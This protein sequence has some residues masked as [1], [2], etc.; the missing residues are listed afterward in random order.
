MPPQ[1]AL[2]LFSENILAQLTLYCKKRPAN[3]KERQR[4]A[5][6]R[7]LYA[8]NRLFSRNTASKNHSRR[9]PCR[10]SSLCLAEKSLALECFAVLNGRF[11]LTGI[12]RGRRNTVCISRTM[13]FLWGERFV[14]NRVNPYGKPPKSAPWCFTA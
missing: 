7:D 1:T 9:Q 8:P 6:H 4:A 12:S 2:F 11:L 5:F 3:N 14:Q 13:D 10:G